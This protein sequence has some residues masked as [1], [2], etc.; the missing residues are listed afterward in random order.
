MG[1]IIVIKLPQHLARFHRGSAVQ[2]I[3]AAEFLLLFIFSGEI[4]DNAFL[5]RADIFLAAEAVKVSLLAGARR[6]MRK[7]PQNSHF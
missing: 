5:H 2:A 7:R 3:L 1:I 4:D 6:Q